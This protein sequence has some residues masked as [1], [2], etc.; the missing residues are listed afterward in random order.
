MIEDAYHAAKLL[1]EAA[2]KVP[3]A[4]KATRIFLEHVA[5][6]ESVKESLLKTSEILAFQALI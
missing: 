1:F 6:G 4:V 5:R 2:E 3:V